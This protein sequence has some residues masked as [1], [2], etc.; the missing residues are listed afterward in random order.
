MDLRNLFEVLIL[1]PLLSDTE[2]DTII[3]HYL[4]SKRHL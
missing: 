4:C 2:V 3:L 1:L